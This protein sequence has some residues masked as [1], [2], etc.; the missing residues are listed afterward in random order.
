MGN[1]KALQESIKQ[2]AEEDEQY[3]LI[4]KLS[5]IYIQKGLYEDRIALLHKYISLYRV[6]MDL[7]HE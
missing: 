4:Q 6:R 2:T 1:I 3:H 5:D 7:I